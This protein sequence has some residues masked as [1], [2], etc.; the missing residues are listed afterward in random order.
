MRGILFRG[1]RADN[2][3]WA[4]SRC[5]DG[6]LR[7]G[8]VIEDFVPET[9]GQFTGLNDKNGTGIFEGDIIK[10]H[11]ANAKNAEFVEQVVFHNGRFC[12]LYSNDGGKIFSPLADGVRHIPQDKTVYMDWCE[13]IGNVHDN[14]ELIGG[15]ENG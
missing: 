14:P 7:S 5:P 15:V 1:K 9:V 2:G 10:S 11:Y 4:C 6:V 12:G 8:V 13:V 3:E